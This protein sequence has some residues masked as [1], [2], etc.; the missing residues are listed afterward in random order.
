MAFRGRNVAQ[1]RVIGVAALAAAAATTSLHAQKPTPQPGLPQLATQTE[2]A[3]SCHVKLEGPGTLEGL[4][5]DRKTGRPIAGAIVRWIGSKGPARTASSDKEGRFALKISIGANST[6]EKRGDD[7]KHGSDYDDERPHQRGHVGIT[8]EHIGYN[9]KHLELQICPGSNPPLHAVLDPGR[10]FATIKGKITGPNG[11]GIP[12]ALVSLLFRG[13]QQPGFSTMTNDQGQFAVPHVGYGSDLAL[14]VIL[15]ETSPTCVGPIRR[16]LNVHSPIVN[17]DISIPIS[18]SVALRCAPVGEGVKGGPTIYTGAPLTL[19]G[20]PRPFNGP[21]TLGQDTSIQWQQASVD[22]ILWNEDTNMWHSGHLND[23]LKI[24]PT[25][26]LVASDASGVWSVAWSSGSAAALPLSTTWDTVHTKSLAQGPDGSSHVYASTSDGG[27][28]WETDTSTAA[29]LV[30]WVRETIPNCNSIPHLLV[31]AEGRLILAACDTGVYWSAIPAAPAAHGTY[32][33]QAAQPGPGVPASYLK[34]GFARLAKGPGW[35]RAGAMGSI[36]AS[37]WGGSAPND[38]IFWGTWVN[39]QLVLNE[40]NVAIGPGNLF[41]TT[42]RTSIASCPTNNQNTMYAMG[43]NPTGNSGTEDLEAVWQSTDGGRNWSMVNLPPNGAPQDG[44][45]GHQ[46]EYNQA[47]AVSALD[48][49]TFALGWSYASFVSFDGGQSYPL[50][51]NG[52]TSGGALHDDYHALTW[53]PNDAQTLFIGSDGGLASASGIKAGS[54]PTFASYYN[55]HLADL[56]PYHVSP[57]RESSLIATPLQDNSVVYSIAPGAWRQTPGSSG[58]GAYSEFTGAGTFDVLAYVDHSDVWKDT[59]WN[60]TS[61]G[62][63]ATIPV[64]GSSSGLGESV[65]WN[66]RQPSYTNNAG[67]LMYTVDGLGTSVYGLF[68]Q[69][70]GSDVHW[71]SIGSIGAGE[72]V[73]A[74]SSANGTSVFVGTDQGNICQLTAPYT[75]PCQSFTVNQSPA[76]SITGV[77]EFFSTIGMATT[78]SGNVLVLTGDSWNV[79]NGA[80]PTG[81]SFISTDGPSLGSV[82]V[83]NGQNVFVTHDFGGTWLNASQGLPATPNAGELH[84]QSQQDGNS[85]YLSAYGWS[86]FRARLP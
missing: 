70:D 29:P 62:N 71:E 30:N 25:Q 37:L 21:V 28:L 10:Q 47:L 79:S 27:V 65:S 9:K 85:I 39:G 22:G 48:C 33:W 64:T 49:N 82:F 53:D 44:A 24:G 54:T 2:Y 16:S 63:A 80:L 26:A 32:N 51:L 86:T 4:V 57:S 61:F 68:A 31:I 58:D 73:T 56:E 76:S 60:G 50:I 55:S 78:A 34:A 74:V 15:S 8:F 72:N 77:L 84:F 17:E 43:D 67:E 66:V 81:Q 41:L 42:G 7:D 20:S 35:G 19:V 69:A 45:T 12:D 36:V 59:P 5:R 3:D 75:G 18:P 38:L 13:F 11:Q 1:A 40:A 14:D 23:I 52:A 6:H 46:G 83:T